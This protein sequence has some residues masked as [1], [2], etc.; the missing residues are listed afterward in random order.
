MTLKI[1]FFKKQ[2]FPQ[3]L[4]SIQKYTSEYMAADL[5]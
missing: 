4:E 5:G 2:K 1:F 3:S